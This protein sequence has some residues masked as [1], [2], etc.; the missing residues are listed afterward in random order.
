MSPASPQAAQAQTATPTPVQPQSVDWQKR[1]NDTQPFLSKLQQENQQY[2][3]Q[4]QQWDGLDPREIRQQQQ[5]QQQQAQLASLKPWNRD[6]PEH[7]R[8]RGVRERLKAQYELANELPPET[9]DQAMR[10]INGRVSESDRKALEEYRSYRESEEAMTPEERDDRYREMAAQVF[11]AKL[12]EYEQFQQTRQGTQQFLQSNSEVVDKYRDV[13]LW[14]M[15]HPARREVGVRLAQLEAENEQ[16]RGKATTQT[17]EVE[18][19]RAR[20]AITKQRA[21]VKRD[22]STSGVSDPAAEAARLGL[23]GDAAYDYIAKQH[24]T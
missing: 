20:D 6:H 23:R 21:T 5:A 17:Q 10:A 13:V 1:F 16:L 22:A 24:R 11:S 18:T 19:A 9:R 2:R 4:L 8:F 12:A 3:Q 15:N 7:T 14:G